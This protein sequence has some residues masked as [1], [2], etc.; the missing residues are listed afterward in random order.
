MRQKMLILWEMRLQR[1]YGFYAVYAL[2]SMFYI[3]VLY[4]MPAAWRPMAGAVMIVSDPATMGLFFMG[5]IVLLEKSQRVLPA[6][7]VSPVR[8][9][10]YLVAKLVSLGG[11]SLLVALVLAFVAGVR[12]V[13]PVL[14]G[15]ALLS[16]TFTLVGVLVATKTPT[17]N[18]FLL[19]S[20]P[21]ELICFGPLVFYLL[22]G[23]GSLWR[24]WPTNL[25]FAMLRGQPGAV[26]PGLLGLAPLLA[27]LF[28]LAGRSVAKLWG[29]LGGG[30]L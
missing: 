16:A 4:V 14:V 22:G 12:P 2:L 10:E 9:G 17:L 18:S 5:A 7:A 30:G 13:W 15:T 6:L 19:V 21:V 28:W 29:S 11:I 1:K 3:L 20:V 24:W 25:G 26:L 8:C 27:V 23:E